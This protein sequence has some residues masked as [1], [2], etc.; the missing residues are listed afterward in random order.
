M[1]GIVTRHFEHQ[2][3]HFQQLL[4]ESTQGAQKWFKNED[5]LSTPCFCNYHYCQSIR[6]FPRSQTCLSWDSVFSVR[7]VRA[8]CAHCVAAAVSQDLN[9]YMRQQDSTASASW[10]TSR[11]MGTGT[12][13]DVG[14]TMLAQWGSSRYWDWDPPTY[15]APSVPP[16]DAFTLL[17]GSIT[18]AIERKLRTQ[19]LSASLSYSVLDPIPLVRICANGPDLLRSVYNVGWTSSLTI[20]AI[21]YSQSQPP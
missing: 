11:L 5:H 1:T 7:S 18:W 4:Y 6:L 14:I 8:V 2:Q 20:E 3:F 17:V 12:S 13:D 16:W 9:G 21:A 19:L 10:G 15:C